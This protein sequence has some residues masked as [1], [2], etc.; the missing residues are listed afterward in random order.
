MELRL[1]R[2]S[3]LFD[4]ERG[5]LGFSMRRRHVLFYDEN[6]TVE[7]TSKGSILKFLI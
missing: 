2:I 3:L 5:S 7:T 4:K 6:D 1:E